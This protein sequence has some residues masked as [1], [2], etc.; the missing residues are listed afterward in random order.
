[1]DYNTLL[2]AFDSRNNA[3][4]FIAAFD[5][6]GGIRIDSTDY[7]TL[8]NKDLPGSAYSKAGQNEGHAV[9]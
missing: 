6:D 1:V 9:S 3:A 2:N 8:I 7:N 5:V 4:S